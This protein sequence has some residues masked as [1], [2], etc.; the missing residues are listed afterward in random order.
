MAVARSAPR[1][2]ARSTTEGTCSARRV[3]RGRPSMGAT[4]RSATTSGTIR[5]TRGSSSSA[6]TVTIT[7]SPAGPTIWSAVSAVIGWSSSRCRTPGWPPERSVGS[8]AVRCLAEPVDPNQRR[9]PRACGARIRRACERGSAFG[10]WTRGC[11][12]VVLG[13]ERHVA[14]PFAPTYR[15]LKAQPGPERVPRADET[16]R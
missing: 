14:E 3:A 11:S 5:I 4:F 2:T 7:T 16:P 13:V 1:T 6:R 10:G 15:G 12:S 9:N 8:I